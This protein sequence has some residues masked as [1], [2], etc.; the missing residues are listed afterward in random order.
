M[1]GPIVAQGQVIGTMHFAR[2]SNTPAFDTRDLSHLSALSAHLSVCLVTLQFQR[3]QALFLNTDCLT[4][5]ELQIAKLVAKGLTN[6]EIGVE[7][8]ISQNT[9]KQT[10]KRIFRLNVSS[11]VEMVHGLSRSG[12]S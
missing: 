2:H 8:W 12:V 1:A 11:Q 9:V 4:Q 5:R 3:N 6:A 7:L 10:L